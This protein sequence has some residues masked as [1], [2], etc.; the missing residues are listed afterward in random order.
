[1]A[2]FRGQLNLFLPGRR[3]AKRQADHKSSS[4]RNEITAASLTEYQA[5]VRFFDIALR[6]LP[7]GGQNLNAAP[8]HSLVPVFMFCPFLLSGVGD[9]H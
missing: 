8:G 6:L 4:G 9:D 7:F 5:D 3:A 1:M 2:L